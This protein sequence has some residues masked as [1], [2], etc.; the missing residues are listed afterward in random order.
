MKFTTFSRT[1]LGLIVNFY[2]HFYL[3]F[4]LVRHCAVPLQCLWHKSVTLI[5]TCLIIIITVHIKQWRIHCSWYMSTQH[6]GQKPVDYH[7]SGVVG[8]RIYHMPIL[9]DM[10][11]LRQ[12][13]NTTSAGFQLSAVDKATDQR[14]R[15]LSACVHTQGGHIAQLFWHSLSRVSWLQ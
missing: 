5:S 2:Q 13:W 7:T 10:A 6:P 11:D 1:I 12:R 9:Q 3:F 4:L 8:E 14:Q 15:R